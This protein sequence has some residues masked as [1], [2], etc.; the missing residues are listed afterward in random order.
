MTITPHQH[1]ILAALR[2]F[3]LWEVT[4]GLR[5]DLRN[6]L[7]SIRNASFYLQRRI[8]ANAE[9]IVKD[10]RIP[11]FFELIGSELGGVDA[12]LEAMPQLDPVP[13]PAPVE[14]HTA[15]VAAA[16][17]LEVPDDVTLALPAPG[18]AAAGGAVEIG[19]AAYCL[20]SN[21]I[22]AQHAVGGGTVDITTSYRDDHAVLAITDS[23]GGRHANAE[24]AMFTTKP[25]RL[26]VGLS[27]VK[28]VASRVRG[29]FEL[30]TVT[31]SGT[32]ATLLF[33]R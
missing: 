25:G 1:A 32:C 9:L 33:R 12:I 13:A 10:P 21:A 22:D 6:K 23:G 29:T 30:S 2:R 17:L 19:L 15:I 5:H 27:I 11:T 7:A 24:R 20:L 16:G 3:E 26:G 8:G 31:P 18:V 28:R 4:G 14:L